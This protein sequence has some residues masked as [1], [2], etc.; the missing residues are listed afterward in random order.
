MISYLSI[1]GTY[2]PLD[3]DVGS[4]L[5][6]LCSLGGRCLAIGWAVAG[7]GVSH[8]LPHRTF[9]H[10][11]GSP[12]LDCPLF[13]PNHSTPIH[14]IYTYILP[15]CRNV[16]VVHEMKSHDEAC[17]SS[18]KKATLDTSVPL[19]S[20]ASLAIFASF[21]LSQSSYC[22]ETPYI[23]L[24]PFIILSSNFRNLSSS[25]QLAFLNVAATAADKQDTLYSGTKR[26]PQE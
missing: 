6:D 18:R 26:S 5:V 11:R 17:E 10:E 22:L 23:Q 24:S 19:F 20:I 2:I 21:I 3:M 12:S 16:N 9:A 13:S 7:L 4:F 25:I 14:T 8:W 1:F 15:H